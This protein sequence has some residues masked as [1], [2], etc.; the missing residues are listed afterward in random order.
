MADQFSRTALLLGEEAIDRLKKSRVAV[1]GIGGVGAAAVEAL[2]RSGVGALVLVDDDEVA[3]TN[4]NR[5]LIALHS[6]LGQ[7]KV[8]AARARVLDINPDCAVEAHKTFYLPGEGQGLMDG[9]DYVIDAIDTVTAKIALIREALEKGIP[10]VSSMGTGNK[11]D[12]SQLRIDDLK[13]TS[14]CPLCRV[15]RRE[16]KKRG[17][18]HLKVLFS[19]EEP[20]ARGVF[21]PEAGDLKNGRQPPA[22]YAVVP[23]VAGIMLAGEVIKD[24]TG[25]RE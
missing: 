20:K 11:L 21:D 8:E 6:T 18:E 17:I 22:S 9:C 23:P 4:L 3:L 5:Q 13:N 7:P 25:V 15:M 14:V 16:L 10:I 12:P 2:A 1:F 19:K 24:L